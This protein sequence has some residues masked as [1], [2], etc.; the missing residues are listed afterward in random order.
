MIKSYVSSVSSGSSVS[1]VMSL[2]L[3]KIRLQFP[4]LSE[5]AYLDNAATAQTPQIAIDAVSDFYEDS[6]ANVHRGLH[7]L[8]EKATEAYEDARQAISKFINSKYSEEI[9]F[10]S[11]T[12]ESINLVARSL[13]ESEL[14]EGDKIVLTVLEHHSNITPW[15]QLKNRTGAEVSWIDID[16]EGNLK[17]DELDSI[18]D[19]GNVSLVSVTGLSNVIGV[20]PPIEEIIK[21]AHAKGAK[22]LIDA[23][24]LA[25]HHKID[26]QKLDCDFLAFSGH[27]VYGPM[28]IGVLYGKK[29]LLESMPPFQTGGGMIR[30]V[31]AESFTCADLPEK[32]EA[33]TP[34]VAEAVGLKT[35]IDWLSQFDWKDIEEHEGKLIE[36]AIKELTSINSLTILCSKTENRKPKTENRSSSI[37]FTIDGVHP[38]DLTDI[39]GEKGICL[40]AGHHCAQPLHERFN[41][42]AS[43]RLSIGIYNTEEEILKV[44]PAIEEAIRVFE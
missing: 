44:K 17:M 3:A 12:T 36:L 39:L 10:T 9:I 13:G 1:F 40:R 19:E 23:A 6:N 21:K 4:I 33:G 15:L 43:T 5:F 30:S 37:G 26:V 11:G 31:S 35:A 8:A 18:L 14:K 38:H 25:A 28:G 22:V 42:E 7:P 32:F 41:V 20:R 34:P 16:D 24:Q 27:K 29:D 2:D